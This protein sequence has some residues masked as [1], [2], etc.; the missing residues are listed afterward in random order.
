LKSNI[1]PVLGNTDLQEISPDYY[2]NKRAVVGL[3]LTP[4]KIEVSVSNKSY[5]NKNPVA[6]LVTLV[7]ELNAAF[8]KVVTLLAVFFREFPKVLKSCRFSLAP[9]PAASLTKVHPKS[10]AINSKWLVTYR[11]VCRT[12]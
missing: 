12:S 5:C 6:E 7:T 2:R 3:S 8:F 1:F 10:H 9:K 11:P 4:K